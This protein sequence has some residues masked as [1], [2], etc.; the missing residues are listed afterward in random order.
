MTSFTK[1][2]DRT[3]QEWDLA[4]EPPSGTKGKLRYGFPVSAQALQAVM[5]KNFG[6]EEQTFDT[7]YYS[8][9]TACRCAAR[10]KRPLYRGLRGDIE[11]VEMP[12]HPLNGM[13]IGVASNE[14][15]KTRVLPHA[16]DIARL[17]KLLLTDAEPEWFPIL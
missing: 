17:K 2:R 6:D 8:F 12:G 3:G 9:W 14:S 16:D 10:T 15:W 1:I 5:Q 13:I 11:V 7:T 4:P